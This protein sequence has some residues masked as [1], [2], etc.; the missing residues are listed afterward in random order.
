MNEPKWRPVELHVAYGVQIWRTTN[1]G[2]VVQEHRFETDTTAVHVFE[3]LA[4]LMGYLSER[5]K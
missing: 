1:N 2:Y 3:S 4:S 5:L